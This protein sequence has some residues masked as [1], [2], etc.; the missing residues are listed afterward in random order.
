MMGEGVTSNMNG[1]TASAMSKSVVRARSYA[2]INLYLDVLDRRDDGFHNIETIFQTVGLYDELT[3]RADERFLTLTCSNPALEITPRNLVVR[4]AHVLRDHCGCKSG[5]VISLDKRIPV[6]AGLAGGS[7]NA[8]ATLSALNEL[9]KLHLDSAA[10]EHIGLELGS[11]VP[12]CLRGGTVAATGRGERMGPLEPLD[13]V[14]I[15]LVHPPFHV[16]TQWVYSHPDLGHNSERPQNGWTPSFRAAIARLHK[17]DRAASIFNRME[18]VVFLQY[19]VLREIKQALLDGGC[20]AA[21]MSG[22]GPTIF[23]ICSSIE[24]ARAIASGIR[25]YATSVVPPVGR[26]IEMDPSRAEG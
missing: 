18:P 13:G 4:A 20:E 21:A 15:V 19:P 7:G 6:A 25:D 24:Q 17:R 2:K 12:Y 14:W 23:G 1:H 9:W 11:D 3:F 16:S 5:A 8:A 26:G 22:S 10:L